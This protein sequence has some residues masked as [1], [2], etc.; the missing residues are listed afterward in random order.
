MLNWSWSVNTTCLLDPSISAWLVPSWPAPNAGI[1]DSCW[2]LLH[3][4]QHRYCFLFS[5]L[6]LGKC[7]RIFSIYF[8]SHATASELAPTDQSPH[9]P[10]HGQSLFTL[11]TE[12]ALL[13]R[14]PLSYNLH[15]YIILWGRWEGCS[16]KMGPYFLYL[17]RVS[18]L[19]SQQK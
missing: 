15:A 17:S 4:L 8:L 7:Y 1:L 5:P 19:K 14:S 18:W 13:L 2:L 16:V 10:E 3:L 9:N 12:E 6:V 11:T